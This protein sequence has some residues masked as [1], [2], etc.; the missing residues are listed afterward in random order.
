MKKELIPAEIIENKIYI[1]RGIKV[2]IDTDLA[3]FYGEETKMLNRAVKRNIERFPESFMFQLTDEEAENLRCQNGTSL[4]RHGGRRY[5]PYVFTEHGVVMLSS[6]L[7]TQIAIA[8]SIQIVDVFVKI[9]Q[10]A[11]IQTELR[12]LEQRFMVYAKDT[13]LELSDHER[14]IN[15][16]Y[17]L[18]DNLEDKK[19]GKIGFET[20]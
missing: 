5:N 8:I 14:L 13:T 11:S 4:D 7:N 17:R 15:K 2:M 10:M 19:S 16:L 18:L 1:V 20:E 12:E 3:E 6:V 9:K